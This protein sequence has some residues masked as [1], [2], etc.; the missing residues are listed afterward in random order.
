M[1]VPAHE[2][3]FSTSIRRNR[4][5]YILANILLFGIVAIVVLFLWLVGARRTNAGVMIFLAFGIPAVICAYFLTAQ[6]VRDLN[7]S[8]WLALLWIPV[9]IADNYIGGAAS[10]AFWIVLAAVPGTA[11]PNRYG[12]DPLGERG[13]AA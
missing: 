1:S 10:L 13:A 11:G 3:W 9:G 5:S 8:G 6:R 12:S 2:D 7:L 4:K